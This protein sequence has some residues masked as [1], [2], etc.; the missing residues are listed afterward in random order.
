M[1][2]QNIKK[3]ELHCHLDGI[4]NLQYFH[5]I[6]KNKFPISQEDLGKYRSC[7][8]PKDLNSWLELLKSKER[9]ITKYEDILFEALDL[10][11]SDLAR[12]NVIYSEIMLSNILYRDEDFQNTVQTFEKYYSLKLKYRPM[13]INFTVGIART[14]KRDVFEKKLVRAEKLFKL[15]LIKG[16]AIAGDEYGS[17]IKDYTEFFKKMNEFHM[18]I[19][20]HA[21]ESGGPERIWDALQ[22]GYCK[23]IGHGL[24]VFDDKKLIDYILKNEIHLEFCPSSNRI[25][26]KY[27]ELKNHPINLARKYGMNFSIN[28]DD[29]GDFNTN[30]T[31]EYELVRQ[32][33]GFEKKDFE[34]IL[35]NSLTAGF[36]D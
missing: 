12:Q 6:S 24:A 9:I 4:L 1:D 16:I 14:K 26:T 36:S 8:P 29:P 15:N 32:Y 35:Y 19:E 10:Y 27:K 11:F 34:N 3:A 5:V 2:S 7:F 22:Y 31:K 21:G 30:I 33:C 23:R 20:I 28:T 13:K 17:D 25:L 18:G